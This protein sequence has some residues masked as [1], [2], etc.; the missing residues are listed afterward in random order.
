MKDNDWWDNII[1]YIKFKNF[2]ALIVLGILLVAL[3]IKIIIKNIS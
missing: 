2:F 3:I 1:N